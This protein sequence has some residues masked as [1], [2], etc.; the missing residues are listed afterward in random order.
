MDEDIVTGYTNMLA[1]V[2]P[3]VDLRSSE[4]TGVEAHK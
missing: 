1:G 4:C 2:A 3:Q